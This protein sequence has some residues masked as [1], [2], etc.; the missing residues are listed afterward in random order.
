MA[1]SIFLRCVFKALANQSIAEASFKKATK[2]RCNLSYWVARGRFM[3]WLVEQALDQV[4]LFEQPPI[5]P[6]NWE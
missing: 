2:M 3:L 6:C 5:G 4:T 1:V